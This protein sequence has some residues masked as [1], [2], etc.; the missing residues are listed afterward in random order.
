M[1]TDV[2]A[3]KSTESWAIPVI[4]RENL[5]AQ[6]AEGVAAHF[7]PDEAPYM[8]LNP[9]Q[10][11]A[12]QLS[13]EKL[14]CLGKDKLVVFSVGRAPFAARKDEVLT[15]RLEELLLAYSMTI[16]TLE[17]EITIAYNAACADLFEPIVLALRD[18]GQAPKDGRMEW[19]QVN[20]LA[21]HDLKFANYMRQLVRDSGQLV[22]YVL[23]P[24]MDVGEKTIAAAHLVVLTATELIWVLNEEKAWATEPVY[25]AIVMIAPRN[26][27]VGC[28]IIASP[29]YGLVHLSITLAGDKTWSIPFAP[30]RHEDLER[31]IARIS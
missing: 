18:K 5:P 31:F 11:S 7:A 21:T 14:I 26:R 30:E 16:S 4:A 12:K 3:L 20:D 24:E 22:D 6:F 13:D 17:D 28:T 8:L 15:L 25:G 10:D 2:S 9:R 27:L 1:A 29:E 19:Q 23:Q